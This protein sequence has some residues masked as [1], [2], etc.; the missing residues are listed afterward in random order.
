MSKKI[1]ITGVS[2]GLGAELAVAF[3][4]QG[5]QVH[6]LGR[7][8]APAGVVD[9]FILCDLLDL[10]AVAEVA[11]DLESESYDVFIHNAMWTPAHAPFIRYK[12]QDFL[13]AHTVATVAPA[14]LLQK[15]GMGMKKLGAG[16]ILFIG[17]L[18]Q[19]TGSE[20]QLPYLTA[21][22]ALSGLVKGLAVELGKHGVTSN[23][24]LLGAVDTPKVRENLSAEARA[25]LEAKLPRGE[26]ITTEEV[27]RTLVHLI[28]GDLRL[29]NGSD[30]LITDSQHLWKGK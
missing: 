22:S 11:K 17:S 20:G 7:S 25:S 5:H 6:G 12:A 15:I 14:L 27:C 4:A 16:Q 26:L 19:L 3:K 1:L 18:I 8:A 13:N 28:A 23:L 29:L 10:A 9:R 24:V 30:I 21:K 2:G